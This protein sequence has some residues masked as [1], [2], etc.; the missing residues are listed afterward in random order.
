MPPDSSL[1]YLEQ[2]LSSRPSSFSIA[3]TRSRI[4][5]VLQLG[6][7]DQWERDVVQDVDG[8]EQRRVLVDHP[9]LL[10]HLVERPLGQ[11]DDVL[12]L[13]EQ[14]AARRLLEG[15]DEP[16][17]RRLAG[18]RPADDDARLA[19]PR[20]EVDPLQHLG[21]AVALA[22]VPEHDHVVGRRA[23]ARDGAEVDGGERTETACGGHG[24]RVDGVAMVGEQLQ[25]IFKNAQA[26]AEKDGFTALPEGT[27]ATLYAAH[28]G[29]ALTVSRVEAIRVDDG[30]LTART[31]KR[32]TYMVDIT[33]VFALAV[34]GATNGPV[35]RAGFG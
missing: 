27:T 6:V 15:D 26:K 18:A 3:T 30:L 28:G 32:E 5:L 4:S 9:E 17:Q 1:G 12:P 24:P 22:D 11:S 35:R 31:V 20:D 25:A 23:A 13:D 16:E 2:T 8:V 21:L 29:V 14:L 19:P 33:D 34:D 7:L 10:A